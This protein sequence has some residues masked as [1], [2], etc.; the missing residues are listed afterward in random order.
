MYAMIAC[1]LRFLYHTYRGELAEAA[2]HR[3]KAEVHAA[4]LG[5][6]WQ[7]DTWEPAALI[8]VASKLRD[9]VALTRIADRL[10]QSSESVPS[11]DLYRQLAHLALG[12]ARGGYA[13]IESIRVWPWSR[14]TSRA[15]SSGGRTSIAVIARAANEVGDH[16]QARAL[17]EKALAHIADEDREFVALFLDLD[18]EMANCAR[19]DRRGRRRPGAAS[20]A[21]SQRFD[22]CDHPMVKGTL[23]EARARIAWKAGR[24]AEYVHSLAAV[25]RWFR[26]TGTAG[27]HREDRAPRRAADR[28]Q[29]PA[30]SLLG[31]GACGGAVRN[32]SHPTA[33]AGESEPPARARRHHCGGPG[34]ASR[35][36]L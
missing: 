1:Q 24:V 23:H 36:A 20:T 5:S 27:P 22:A 9:V 15:A 29:R 31:R 35:E 19:G 18:I 30:V 32:R 34:E 3:E 25:E 12:R 28:A 17:C 13:G 11:L 21:C 10:E 26:P 4:H 33:L 8:P 7:V 14:R 6:A 16:A 2:V